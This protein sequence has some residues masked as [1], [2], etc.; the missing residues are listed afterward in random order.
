MIV[1]IPEDASID[2]VL[3]QLIMDTDLEEVKTMLAIIE[4]G[5]WYRQNK[6]QTACARHQAATAR[7]GWS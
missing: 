5:E 6:D 1:D 3:K 2:D 4:E 7:L